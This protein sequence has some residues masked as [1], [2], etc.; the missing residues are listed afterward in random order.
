MKES[1]NVHGIKT[2]NDVNRLKNGIVILDGIIACEINKKESLVNIVYDDKILDL[3][4]IKN[5]I[6]DMGY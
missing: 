3:D 2:W 5:E 4:K 6:E 1:I